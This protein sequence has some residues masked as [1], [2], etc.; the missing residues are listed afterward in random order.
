MSITFEEITGDVVADR[1]REPRGDDRS[2][3]DGGG[4]AFAERVRAT[5]LREKRRL[6]RLSDQ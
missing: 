1:P 4:L 5:L 3:S 2:G 6:E